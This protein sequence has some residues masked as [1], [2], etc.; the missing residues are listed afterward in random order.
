MNTKK[1][2]KTTL[3]RTLQAKRGS[4]N[5][6][7]V[8]NRH[9]TILQAKMI[10]DIQNQS[11][12]K[13]IS[14]DENQVIQRHSHSQK[15][16]LVRGERGFVGSEEGTEVSQ[17]T[18][19]VLGPIDYYIKDEKTRITGDKFNL[20]AGHLVKKEYGGKGDLPN[21]LPW[22]EV[23][24]RKTWP[25]K[26]ETPVVEKLNEMSPFDDIDLTYM[27]TGSDSYGLEDKAKKMIRE[28]S[29]KISTDSP[30]G[31][32]KN[33]T[34]SKL[35]NLDTSVL[36]KIPLD[37][38]AEVKMTPRS[39][40]EDPYTEERTYQDVGVDGQP[41]GYST[42]TIVNILFSSADL[43]VPTTESVIS[44]DKYIENYI[45]KNVD[46]WILKK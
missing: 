4:D 33:L 34:L 29:G 44:A 19:K 2:Y 8:D 6:G 45:D 37:V 42:E 23:F 5:I 12:N 7:F 24:E 32:K 38:L 36:S 16:S 3:F 41:M 35:N 21:I 25:E 13:D 31:E 9:I 20:Q 14:C 43:K 39:V 10:N 28:V 46:G 15:V 11:K 30:D 40:Y 27:V 26:V 17:A 1:Q 22:G 18:R